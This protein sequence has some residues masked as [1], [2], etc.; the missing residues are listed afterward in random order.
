MFMINCSNKGCFKQNEHVVD[1]TTN[2]VICIDCGKEIV[3]V[4]DFTKRQM[5]SL[6]QIKRNVVQ[7]Q[8]WAVKCDKCAKEAPP[9]L[10]KDGKDLLCSACNK[11]LDKLAKP[12]ASS[13]KENLRAQRKM[14]S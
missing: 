5:I 12:F 1:K 14:K 3:G 9:V 11:P 2:Q 6:G 13:I 7:K 8:A 10:D 4:T